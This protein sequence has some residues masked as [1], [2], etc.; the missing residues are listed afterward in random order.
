[1]INNMPFSRVIFTMERQFQK[2]IMGN[3]YI[4]MNNV[5]LTSEEHHKVAT[6]VI[7]GIK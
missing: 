1:M 5:S 4:V 6:Y 7:E 3:G 2:Y